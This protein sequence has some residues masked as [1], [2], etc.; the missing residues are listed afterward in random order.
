MYA[1]IDITARFDG[2]EAHGQVAA[3]CKNDLLIL[4]SSSPRLASARRSQ[5]S[6]GLSLGVARW[7]VVYGIKHKLA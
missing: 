1:E 2:H 3:V 6:H 5:P 7:A 4:Q